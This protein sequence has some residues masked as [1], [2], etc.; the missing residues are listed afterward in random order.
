MEKI[1]QIYNESQDHIIN[2]DRH[3]IDDEANESLKYIE[4]L[5][6]GMF[7]RYFKIETTDN[8]K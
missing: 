7:L 3:I 6:D 8:L 4:G 1:I 2:I 5:I